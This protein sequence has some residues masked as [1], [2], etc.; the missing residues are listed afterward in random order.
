M[1]LFEITE[2]VVIFGVNVIVVILEGVELDESRTR[3]E[4]FD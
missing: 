3:F 1:V 2:T 4:V